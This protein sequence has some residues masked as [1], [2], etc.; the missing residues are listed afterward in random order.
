LAS[1]GWQFIAMHLKRVAQASHVTVPEYS[2]DS[3]E[4]WHILAINDDALSN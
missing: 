3:R 1:V 2:H 4:K